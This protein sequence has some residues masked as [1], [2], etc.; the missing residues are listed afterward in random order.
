MA[1]RTAAGVETDLGP[2]H[3]TALLDLVL[4]PLGGLLALFVAVGP[5]PDD[6]VV[7]LAE[8]PDDGWRTLAA[9]LLALAASD[10]LALPA[11]RGVTSS[12]QSAPV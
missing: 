11:P 5:L 3:E 1:L 2:A 9:A 4:P 10:K 7:V 8:A 12:K 6:R